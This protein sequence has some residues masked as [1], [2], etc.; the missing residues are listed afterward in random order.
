MAI[1]FVLIHGGWHDGSCWDQTVS[2]LEAAGHR[3]YAPTMAGHGV[4]GGKAVT[5]A[6]CVESVAA[7]ITEHDLNDFVLVG[8]SISGIIISK[9]AELMP[10]R[11][12]RHFEQLEARGELVPRCDGAAL[13]CDWRRGIWHGSQRLALSERPLRRRHCNVYGF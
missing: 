6:N 9:T 8:H 1:D 11:V 3:A 2:H 4:E 5:I 7:Y 12:R 13:V 10:D